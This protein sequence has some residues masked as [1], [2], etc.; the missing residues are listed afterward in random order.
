MKHTLK[1]TLML[2]LLFMAM[3]ATTAFTGSTPQ[4]D[5]VVFGGTFVLPAGETLDGNLVILG[6][7]VTLE[8][9][10]MVTGD[11]VLVGGSLDANGTLNGTLAIVGGLS[12]LGDKAIANGDIVSIGGSLTRAPNS[13]VKG[14]VSN[15]VNAPF[16]L[17]IPG[18]SGQKLIPVVPVYNSNSYL[19]QVFYFLGAVVFAAALAMLIALLWPKPTQRVANSIAR[20]PIG[21]GGF[22]CLT[23]IVAPGLLLL[24][25]ITILLIPLSLLGFF[26]LAVAAIFGWT[27]IDL[28]VGNRLAKLFRTSW[29]TPIATGIGALVF[30]FVIFGLAWIPCFGQV[31]VSLVI[32]FALGGVLISRFG[33]HEYLET[34]AAP[35]PMP[36]K[37]AQPIEPIA[38][39]SPVITSQPVPFY[40][41]VTKPVVPTTKPKSVTKTTASATIAKRVPAAKKPVAKKTSPQPVTRKTSR[42]NKIK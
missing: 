2:A 28:E 30:N 10:S 23:M 4:D 1:I 38:P 18:F 12:H 32:L 22:G 41:E 42:T 26:L 36:V 27:A 24:I 5:K 13:Q 37:M 17:T 21:T 25:A 29:S 9:G 7:T 3:L 19:W 35:R 6:G 39:Y 11:T 20:N 34:P 31:L 16:S 40:P 8:Q 33:T 14:E 15:F